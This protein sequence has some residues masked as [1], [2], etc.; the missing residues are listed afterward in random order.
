MYY[1]ED[2]VTVVEEGL[3]IKQLSDRSNGTFTCRAVV[4]E[5]GEVQEKQINLIVSLVLTLTTL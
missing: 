3:L 4:P 1:S 2:P 5:T